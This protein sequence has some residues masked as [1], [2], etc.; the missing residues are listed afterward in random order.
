MV[1]KGAPCNSMNLEVLDGLWLLSAGG[2][3]GHINI[4]LGDMVVGYSLYGI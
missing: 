4:S 3:R 1:Y 2:P